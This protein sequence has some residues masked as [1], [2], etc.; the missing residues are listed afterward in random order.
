MKDKGL[1]D[2]LLTGGGIMNAED[3]DKLKAMGCGELFTPGASMTE[4]VE[5]VKKWVAGVRSEV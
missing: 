5:Y 2:V 1:H 3:I 4:I